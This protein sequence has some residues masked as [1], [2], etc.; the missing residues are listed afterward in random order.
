MRKQDK[1]IIWPVYF[2]Q[3]K[4][5]KKGRRV[6]RS[7][8]VP[9]PSIEEIREAALRLG[10]KPEV[11][12]DSGYP[13]VPWQ[14]I[15]MVKVEKEMTKEQTITRIAKQ[16]TKTRSAAAPTSEKTK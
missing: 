7:L 4:T 15:G 10:L 8:A 1:A 9:C 11:S 2:D 16:L 5:R 12:P 13:R 14:K 3:T 6:P